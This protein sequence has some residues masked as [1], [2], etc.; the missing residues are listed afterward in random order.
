MF[1]RCRNVYN[2]RTHDAMHNAQDYLVDIARDGG[3]RE[4]EITLGYWKLAFDPDGKEPQEQARRRGL[5]LDKIDGMTRG[6]F[7]LDPSTAPR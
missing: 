5:D 3:W 6:R 4:F 7:E 1:G 2:T